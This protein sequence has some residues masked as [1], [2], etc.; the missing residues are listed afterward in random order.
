MLE[1]W[2]CWSGITPTSSE[3]IQPRNGRSRGPA[4]FVPHHK[5]TP[6]HLMQHPR[7]GPEPQTVE[8][9]NTMSLEAVRNNVQIGAFRHRAT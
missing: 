6:S 5:V 4:P 9:L 7:P 8:A 1:A 3:P 2:R